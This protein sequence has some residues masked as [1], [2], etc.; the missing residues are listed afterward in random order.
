MQTTIWPFKWGTGRCWYFLIGTTG[1]QQWVL[2]FPASFFAKLMGWAC[3]VL[4][5]LIICSMGIT[6]NKAL[7]YGAKK[8]CL[9]NLIAQLNAECCYEH[10]GFKENK[11][12]HP[13]LFPRVKKLGTLQES[14]N[15]WMSHVNENMPICTQHQGTVGLKT[16]Q[17]MERKAS[18]VICCAK[19]D[20]ESAK[21]YQ[22]TIQCQLMHHP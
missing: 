15:T 12:P 20:E 5:F 2:S 22:P 11:A 7:T 6:L 13:T 19:A 21:R 8:C 1:C 14:S 16:Y 4:L 10:Q 18:S 3:S 9:P 17:K